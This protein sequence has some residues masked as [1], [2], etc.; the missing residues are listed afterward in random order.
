[1]RN[2]SPD[3]ITDLPAGIMS[4]VPY[5]FASVMY[6]EEGTMYFVHTSRKF[7]L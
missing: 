7:C 6:V 1:M 4:H 2:I 3:R 5:L